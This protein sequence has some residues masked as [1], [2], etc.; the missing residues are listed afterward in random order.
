MASTQLLQAASKFAVPSGIAHTVDSV[1]VHTVHTVRDSLSH[2][3]DPTYPE[4]FK[5]WPLPPA[6]LQRRHNLREP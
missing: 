6:W 5:T 2:G 3:P 4:V 1:D